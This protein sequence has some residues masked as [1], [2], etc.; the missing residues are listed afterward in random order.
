M[1]GLAHQF[2]SAQAERELNEYL[3]HEVKNPIS[4][5]MAAVSFVKLATSTEDP[6]NVRP[7]VEII[8]N[9]L[10]FVND[11]LRNMLDMHRASNRQLKVTLEPTDI[12]VDVLEP[13]RGML[14]QRN[15]QMDLQI[16]CPG[17]LHVKTDRLRL[18]QICLNLGRNSTKFIT[19]GFIRFSVSISDRGTVQVAVE[20][21]GSGVPITKRTQLFAKFQESLDILNQGTGVGLFLCKKLT[22]LMGGTIYL[23]DTYHSGI[24]GHPGARFVIDLNVP[25]LE[26]NEQAPSTNHTTAE[27][28]GD[29]VVLPENLEVLFV[30][31]NAVLRKLFARAVKLAAPTWNLHQASNG[32]TAIRMVDES[33]VDKFDIIFVDMY[34][35]SVEK[36]LLGTEAVVELRSRGVDSVICGLSAN[37]KERE[38]KDAGADTFC[39]KPFPCERSALTTELL[40]VLA[41]RNKTS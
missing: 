22:E 36:Q 3:E 2:L 15:G 17:N 16:N 5:A 39:V 41:S 7:D 19:T 28:V 13:V 20:D 9:S 31:D 37:D 10:T 18:K 12:M 38:F 8:E 1:Q 11:L 33:G 40:R 21:S 29:V 32:E 23:D 30:D 26:I 14:H 6:S 27:S 4:A 25:P 34:M 35:A 24:V